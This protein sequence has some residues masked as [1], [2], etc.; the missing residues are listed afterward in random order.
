MRFTEGNF[1]VG[2]KIWLGRTWS[3]N[4]RKACWHKCEIIYHLR[5]FVMA[6]GKLVDAI[7]G[8]LSLG[9]WATRFEIILMLLLFYDAKKD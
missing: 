5:R 4:H 2:G 6:I 9:H 1:W 7:V 8:I 3:S